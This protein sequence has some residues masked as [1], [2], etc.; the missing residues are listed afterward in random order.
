MCWKNVTFVLVNCTIRSLETPQTHQFGWVEL[1]RV[2]RRR[3]YCC[4][5]WYVALSVCARRALII[6][7]TLM[8]IL[9]LNMCA[10]VSVC[11]LYIVAHAAFICLCMIFS[12]FHQM[13]S[14]ILRM[15]YCF[16]FNHR[17]RQTQER[18]HSVR[19]IRL[20]AILMKNEFIHLE[21]ATRTKW[22]NW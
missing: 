22:L 12:L 6:P 10:Y 17:E 7:L 13:E 4:C 21:G 16:S 15:P 8:S 14:A 5:C 18:R 11:A 2:R 19:Q 9:Y 3:C 1:S 20:N